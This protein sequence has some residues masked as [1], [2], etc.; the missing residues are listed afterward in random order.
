MLRKQSIAQYSYCMKLKIGS[1]ATGNNF[2]P[3]DSLRAELLRAL[4]RDQL[5]F[6]GPRR[7]GKTSVLRDL[8][9]NPPD[10]IHT[11]WL[12]LE[13]IKDVPTWINRMLKATRDAIGQ[14]PGKWSWLKGMGRKTK[15]LLNR[16][17]KIEALSVRIKVT[18][19][20]SSYAEWEPLA[21][22]FTN[23]LKADQIPIYFL[24]DEFP[25]F[26]EHIAENHTKPE[27]EAV[28]NWFRK[29]RQLLSD[30][31]ARF[32]VTGSIGLK[33]LLRRLQ[34]SPSANDF[35]SV[36]MK[37][38]SEDEALDYLEQISVGEGI[39]LGDPA[40]RRIL[41]R[42]GVNWPLLLAIFVS[43]IQSRDFEGGPNVEDIDQ[44]YEGEMVRGN[45]NTYCEEMYSR[46][47]KPELFNT[48]ERSFALRLLSALCRSDQGF[49][50]AEVD[51]LYAEL[52]P[53]DSLRL[54][55]EPERNF[56]LETLCH[57]GYL[58]RV[59]SSDSEL[60]GRYR[61]ASNIL[62]DMWAYKTS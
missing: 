15:S 38:L 22:E 52:I 23:M 40:R 42:L 31:P 13:D 32:L 45:R 17:E 33:G 21:N 30:E 44:I 2:Y 5:K 19:G 9:K 54:E 47:H 3:R 41:E 18:R 55:S 28:L 58:L 26:L 62:R 36:E 8:E 6:L 29:T 61:F 48:S 39:I 16:I 11:V 56:V 43:E 49:T 7:T 37:P 4:E 1:P 20:Q 50:S 14:K 59:K 12:D 27:A 53:D 51:R 25:W 46:L 24:L 10:G 57:D 35:D 34:I 60:D